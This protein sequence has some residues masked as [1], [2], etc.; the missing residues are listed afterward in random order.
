[1][2][3]F[4]LTVLVSIAATATMAQPFGNEWINYDQKYYKFPIAEDGVYRITYQDLVTA[5]IPISLVNP[6]DIQLFA[7]AEEVPIYLEGVDDGVFNSQDFIEFV[8]HKNNG[9]KES[10]LYAQPS[11]QGNPDYS[12][13]NDT[14]HYFITIGNGQNGLRYDSN[15]DTNF[16]NYTPASFVWKRSEV[17]YNNRYHHQPQLLDAPPPSNPN[18]RLSLSEFVTGE[19]WL[20]TQM[21]LGNPGLTAQVNTE[22]VFRGEDAPAA[23]AQTV[24]VG[25]SDM[26]EAGND[27]FVQVKYGTANDLAVNEQYNGYK[28]KVYNFNIPNAKVGDDTTPI[29]HE[30]VNGLGLVRDDQAV[31]TV[32]IVYPRQL[33]IGGA[34]AS[35][36]LYRLNTVQ[37]KTRFDFSQVGGANP[38]IYTEGPN[39]QRSVLT[40][41]DD[42]HKVLVENDLGA[43]EFDFHLT[44]DEAIKSILPIE[45]AANDGFFTEFGLSQ[46][47]SAFVIIT[48][49]SL[50]TAAQS[51]ALYRQNTHN[52]VLVDV[53]EIYD[54]YGYG[55]EKSGLSLR[56]FMN[57]LLQTWELPPQ[58]LLLLGKSVRAATI[59]NLAGMRN[60]PVFYARNLVPSLGYPPSDNFITAGLA[61]TFLEPAVSTGRISAR[62]EEEVF[63]YLDKL[64]S[65]ESWEPN[66]WMK[67]VLHFGGGTNSAEQARFANYLSGYENVA[68]D[69]SF[70]AQ[71]Y[72]Y[73]K[74][75]SEPVQ[76]NVSDEIEYLIEEEGISLMTFFAHAGS[77][78]FDQTIDDPSNFEWNGKYPFLLGNGCYSGD[79]HGPN[80]SSTS[81]KYTLLNQKGVIG[82]L[83]SIDLGI[84]GDLNAF[85]R[86]FYKKFS[87]EN[88]GGTVG[89]HIKR[90]I[91]EVEAPTVLRKYLCLGMGLQG[92][93]AVVLNSFQLPDLAITNQDVYF[94]PEE[95]T[96][97]LD[98]FQ[99]NVVVSNNGE[100]TLQPFN[101]TIEHRLPDGNVEIFNS[102]MNGLLNVDTIQFSIPVDPLQSVGL[103]SF[104]VLVDVPENVIVEQAGKESINNQVLGKQLLITDKG[105]VPIYPYRN[106][107]VP[108]QDVVLKASTGDPL[109]EERTYVFQIDTTDNFNSGALQQMKITQA[110]GVVEWAPSLQ[111]SDSLV[112]F[113]R[114][115]ESTKEDTEWRESNFQYI[116]NKIGWGQAHPYQFGDNSFYGTQLNRPDRTIDFSTGNVVLKNNVIGNSAAFGNNIILNTNE[117]EYGTCLGNPAIHLAVFD[118]ITFEAWGTNAEGLNPDN[119]FGNVNAGG[120]CRQRVEYYFIFW[121]NQPAQMQALAD[122]LL[123]Q[124]IPDGHYVMLYTIRY[125]SYDDWDITPDIYSAFDG[126]GLSTIG[127]PSAQDSVPFSVILRKGDPSFVHEIYGNDISDVLANSVS[128]SRSG[129]IGSF[130][131]PLIGPT[132]GWGEASWV[133]ATLDADP[134]DIANIEIKGVN[135]NGK[136]VTLDGATYDGSTQTIDL[137]GFSG[138]NQYPY[139]RLDA[140]LED[141]TNAT[142]LQIKR[143]HVLHDPVAEA[144]VNPAAHFVF[145]DETLQAGQEGMASVAITNVSEVDMDSLLVNYWIEDSD[146]NRIE[147]PYVRQDSLR[148]GETLIDTVYFDTRFLTGQNI[149]WAEVNPKPIGSAEYDQPEQFHLNNLLQKTFEVTS[150][151]QNPLLDVTFDGIHIINGEIVSPKAMI[152]IAL[153]D[154]NPF[155]LMDEPSDTALFK[156]FISAPGGEL[157]RVF[158]QRPDGSPNMSFL[159]ATGEKN[160]A[161]I[162]F[163]PDLLQDGEHTLLIQAADK[164]GNQSSNM[165]YRI[166]FEIVTKSTITEV[167]NYPN[168]FSTSTQFIF[169]L[170]GS[171]IPDEFKIQ[172]MTI[173]GKVVREIT[174]A[175]FGP[176]RIG[177]NFS[178]YKWDGRDE[179]GDRLG[180]GVYLYRVFARLNGDNID[181]RETDASQY[182]HKSFGK[183]VL[184]R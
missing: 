114:C 17:F 123:S 134:G 29:R 184:F 180:N 87:L 24:V 166:D 53:A 52:T 100:A 18:F 76:I 147:I 71:V 7:F 65:F 96:F 92:D 132:S 22:G 66:V 151:N 119:D 74:T 171:E 157:Q 80:Q 36:F 124:T 159:P 146:R 152:R 107:V 149:F 48:H 176:I 153:K 143:W 41:Q 139:L 51:Y 37:S 113:W 127:T 133:S 161:K 95:I 77:E 39:A 97:E 138:I 47:E 112:F 68:Q 25:V 141:E 15:T 79:F 49:E 46:V 20:S 88:Y 118:P 130:T 64:Q 145:K 120:A 12:L 183:M 135:Q 142:P 125:V 109:A 38:R 155:L 23:E 45:A 6:S 56:N 43:N 116:P 72:T 30:V 99:I 11:D 5:G 70:G 156:I 42:L 140:Y 50:M 115:A 150:D 21:T 174:Q 172:I 106:A 10:V 179:F 91:N 9:K 170:T 14:I 16:D 75:T 162:D 158:F 54:Q 28:I 2:K 148:A 164:S 122:L 89:D 84:E 181:L 128:I 94:T 126:L 175:E 173:S 93:P 61:G 90:T 55:V 34:N 165:D 44:T 117:V 59:G 105:L 83:A 136:A 33:D 27:H 40:F 60:N 168:P 81:E 1:M 73:L 35:E 32:E 144:A 3:Q 4:L 154:E 177:R 13:Y 98:S 182:F 104:D 121:Q 31:R 169:T 101:V 111:Y 160:R 110:G 163:Q 129:T 63:W 58:H 78:G 82:F 108:A 131:S 62:N 137:N 69:S 26:Q 103:H 67:N 167:L 85:S 8:G 19:G 86:S 178:A 57:H 102:V